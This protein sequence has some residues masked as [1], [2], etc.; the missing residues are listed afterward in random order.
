MF[1]ISTFLWASNLVVLL[2]RLNIVFVR[3]GG[4]IVAR[5]SV[6]NAATQKLRY[7]DD[8]MF[9]VLVSDCGSLR[10]IRSPLSLKYLI[11][12]AVLAVSDC[13]ALRI[14]YIDAFRSGESWCCGRGRCG[15]RLSLQGS[16]SQ[17]LVRFLICP[18]DSTVL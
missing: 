14:T 3:R 7:M 9:F 5:L 8:V 6:A 4:P 1:A 18:R 2:E 10:S 12:D 15:S 16:G 13:V 11:G 17:H